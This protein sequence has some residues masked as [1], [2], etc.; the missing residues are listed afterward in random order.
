MPFA[1][2]A[3]PP[4]APALAPVLAVQR[5]GKLPANRLFPRPP[6]T[7]RVVINGKTL[8]GAKPVSD[9]DRILVPMRAIA[10]AM[11][12]TVIYYPTSHKVVY[13]YRG[14][15]ASLVTNEMYGYDLDGKYMGA[16]SRILSGRMYVPL[17]F[18]G[19]S[20]GAQVRWVR[21]S[22]TAYVNAGKEKYPG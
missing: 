13:F 22:R 2:A 17:R 8:S 16:P 12:A 21:S 10:E 4:L 11:G 3:L 15:E 1:I 7:G 20:L 5:R 18:V 19:E 6:G 9:N 14:N